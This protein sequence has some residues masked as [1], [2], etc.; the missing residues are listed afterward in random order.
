MNTYKN[1]SAAIVTFMIAL[2][3]VA[4]WG[5]FAVFM[6]DVFGIWMYTLVK[7]LPTL[8]LVYWAYK[9]FKGRDRNA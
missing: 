6:G 3:A 5:A 2:I 4:L 1:I 9:Y 7:F 8:Y